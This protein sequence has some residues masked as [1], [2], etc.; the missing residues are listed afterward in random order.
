[1][2]LFPSAP[3]AFLSGAGLMPSNPT[4][5]SSGLTPTDPIRHSA[6]L[7]PTDPRGQ[8][9][10]L[11]PTDPRTSTSGSMP[12]NPPRSPKIKGWDG[13]DPPWVYAELATLMSQALRKSRAK[14][15]RPSDGRHENSQLEESA[16]RGRDLAGS[17]LWRWAPEF[18][19]KTVACDLSSRFHVHDKALWLVNPSKPGTALL[20]KASKV[21]ELPP[22]LPPREM[23]KQ[24]DKV[25]RA[26]AEREDRLPEIL[27]QAPDIWPFFE[28]ITG[29]QL[30]QAPR[31]AEL[32][33]VG[34]DWA[35]HL[36]MSLK[37]AMA[38]RRPYQQSTLVMPVISTPGHGALPS[39]HATMA[40]FTSELLYILLYRSVAGPGAHPDRPDHLDRLARRISFN[41]VVA[42]VH[43]PVDS[44]VGY[45]LGTQLAR[46][47][48]A[49]AGNTADKPAP[50]LAADVMKAPYGLEELTAD[51]KSGRPVA[52]LGTY[53]L[54][55]VPT[56]K[57]LWQQAAGELADVRI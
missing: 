25:V 17:A 8:N 3:I 41:R 42:G 34:N 31:F 45:A 53:A 50:M 35:M 26:A 2:A 24:V 37:H 22:P 15:I 5:S 30:S 18:R 23:A 57:L 46:L 14:I 19:V 9:S 6:G 1:M 11:S 16:A 47:M 39:G 12:S 54:R 28:S 21:F 44:Q 40:A 4:A 13:I 56:L 36:L 55:E 48:H 10:A 7:S 51:S 49:L 38:A 52:S 33:A 20:L 29:V 27:S 32:L 43:F